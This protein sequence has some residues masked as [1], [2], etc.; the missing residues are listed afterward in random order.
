MKIRVEIGSSGRTKRI[1]KYASSQA[2]AER[3]LQAAMN[4]ANHSAKQVKFTLALAQIELS[5]SQTIQLTGYGKLSGKYFID[6]VS[7]TY[8]RNGL[9]MQL[10]CSKVPDAETTKV[11]AA[12]ASVT[13]NNAPLYYTSV[14]KKPVRKV[15]GHYFLYDGINVAGRYRITNLKSRCGKTPV[16]KNVTGW[17]NAADVGGV[18]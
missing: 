8:S 6:K 2:D 3:R 11:S 13:L 5:E 4:N 9:E 15:S 14:D 10:E 1:Q 18:T 16:G 17:V 7:L 12:G